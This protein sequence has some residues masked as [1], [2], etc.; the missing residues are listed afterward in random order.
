VGKLSRGRR[1]SMWR[2]LQFFRLAM[3]RS[4]TA[5][6]LLMAVLKSFWQSRSPRCGIFFD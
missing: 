1:L 5:R 4:T 6:I 2:I 3:T